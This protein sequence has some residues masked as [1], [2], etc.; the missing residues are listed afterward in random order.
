MGIV[1]PPIISLLMRAMN[2][3]LSINGRRPDADGDI[4]VDVRSV[5]WSSITDTPTAMPPTAH[6]ATH[7]AAGSDPVSISAAQVS[8]L[9]T[10]G[11]VAAE[12]G[13]TP[14]FL[15]AKIEGSIVLDTI[16]HKIALAGDESTPTDN[17]LY[18]TGGNG[19]K[20]WI[21]QGSVIRTDSNDTS[22]A[23][24]SAK[25]D[26]SLTVD[27][28]AHR[29]IL[30]GDT[31]TPGANKVYGTDASGNRGWQDAASGGAGN[32]GIVQGLT[33]TYTGSNINTVILPGVA[34]KRISILSLV[35]DIVT[36]GTN[37]GG[38]LFVMTSDF[39]TVF[40]NLASETPGV[41]INMILPLFADIFQ[42]LPTGL[43]LAVGAT[44][45]TSAPL[46]YFSI[47]Y[48]VQ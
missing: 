27:T 21:L 19:D 8:G 11:L 42:P 23:I 44:S 46:I 41:Y 15:S 25:V 12:S 13:D 20:G 48:I 4:T 32:T 40:C 7:A 3:V 45:Y 22:P 2:A 14:G 5:D 38:L 35:I 37:P 47:S 30:V 26:K 18:G 6:A 9:P 33:Y 34:N 28:A 1:F 43:G 29:L 36:Q 24:L 16:A 10:P 39:N 17:S 31:A